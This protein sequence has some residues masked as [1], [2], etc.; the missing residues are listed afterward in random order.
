MSFLS[1][2]PGA[3]NLPVG[4]FSKN[5]IFFTSRKERSTLPYTPGGFIFS[6]VTI[7]F[8]DIGAL[9]AMQR[10]SSPLTNSTSM[11]LGIK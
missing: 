3:P 7:G 5:G 4:A 9:M 8:D 6:G 10:E 1:S 2:V 11:R